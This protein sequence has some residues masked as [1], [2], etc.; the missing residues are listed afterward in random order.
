M[1]LIME[2]IIVYLIIGV[3]FAIAAYKIFM[4]LTSRKSGCDGCA[5]DC[6]GC[7]VMELKKNI[8]EAKKNN[9]KPLIEKSRTS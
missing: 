2:E 7:S 5:S 4:T 8:E 6:S 3:A 9:K 1:Y